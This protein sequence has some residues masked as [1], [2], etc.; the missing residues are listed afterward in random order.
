MQYH[1]TVLSRETKQLWTEACNNRADK[2]SE[3]EKI[4]DVRDAL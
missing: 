2:S 4:G 3:L 1:N